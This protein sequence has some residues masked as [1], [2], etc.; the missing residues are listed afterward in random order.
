MIDFA[1]INSAALGS[2]RPLLQRW[3]PDGKVIGREYVA[4]NPRRDDRRL[5]SFKIN[6][7]TG[8]W[9]EFATG[10]RGGDI[11]SLLAYLRGCSQGDAARELSAL[12]GI[13]D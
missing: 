4:L 9:S 2:L 13:A 3:L 6:L 8:R 10:D 12:L 11:V 7:R 5:G 1:A